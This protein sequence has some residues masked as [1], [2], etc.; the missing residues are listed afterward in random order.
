MSEEKKETLQSEEKSAV[1]REMSRR[2]FLNYTLGGTGAFMMTLPLVF[3]L[4]FAID[5]LLQEKQGSD[6]VK[7]VELDK[8]STTPQSFEFEKH[9]VDG[10]YEHDPKMSAWIAL[11][12]DGMPYALSPVCK[13]LGCTVDWNTSSQHPNE[14]FCPCHGAHY[15]KDG[16][17]LAIAREPLDEYDVKVENGAVYLGQLMKNTRVK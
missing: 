12:D 11:G 5:P 3:N 13:H 6:W 4:R 8:L 14:F 9:V 15:T 7:V 2:Q 16:K 1:R 17:N 10:W